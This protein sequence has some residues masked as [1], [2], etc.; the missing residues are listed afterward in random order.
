MTTR[1]DYGAIECPSCHYHGNLVDF[2]T[3]PSS[4]LGIGVL[5]SLLALAGGLGFLIGVS[6]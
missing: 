4:P 2:Q 5:L 6:W 1:A 3:G